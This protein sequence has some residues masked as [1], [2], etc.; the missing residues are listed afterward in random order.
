MAF[1]WTA[2]T[3]TTTTGL[4]TAG[5]GGI[6][7]THAPRSASQ[8]L[9]GA[10]QGRACRVNRCLGAG[11]LCRHIRGEERWEEPFVRIKNKGQTPAP[12][13]CTICAS[14]SLS[15]P[16]PLLSGESMSKATKRKL[17]EAKT[18]FLDFLAKA[19]IPAGEDKLQVEL[20]KHH[21]TQPAFLELN[22]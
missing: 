14:P 2:T 19:E 10:L 13:R 9:A 5:K 3:A 17:E 21:I 16:L 12:E 11:Q 7:L 8:S 6:R 18:T 20:I 1:V 15:F 22:K 4:T